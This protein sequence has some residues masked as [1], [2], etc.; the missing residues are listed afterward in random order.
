MCLSHFSLLSN[1]IPNN[2]CDLEQFIVAFAIMN[3]F[4]LLCALQE[5]KFSMV[6]LHL[7]VSKPSN[8]HLRD[9]C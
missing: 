5:V 8:E 2:F 6:C 7:I 1:T 3:V 4:I 9:T